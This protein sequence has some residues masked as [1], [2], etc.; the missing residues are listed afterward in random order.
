MNPLY[1]SNT[2]DT[3]TTATAFAMADAYPWDILEDNLEAQN[4]L[5]AAIASNDQ[6]RYEDEATKRK[7]D[8]LEDIVQQTPLK[9]NRK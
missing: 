7:L 4:L 5:A 2:L 9:A 6:Y 1:S 3:S 8:R